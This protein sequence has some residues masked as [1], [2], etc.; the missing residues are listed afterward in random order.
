M[1]RSSYLLRL[2]RLFLI[3]WIVM[4]VATRERRVIR[5]SK[6]T[7]IGH[8]CRDYFVWPALRP[9]PADDDTTHVNTHFSHIHEH[10]T[11]FLNVPLEA[12]ATTKPKGTKKNE[13]PPSRLRSRSDASL[14]LQL[15]LTRTPLVLQVPIQN[16]SHRRS[17]QP[18]SP[19]GQEDALRVAR[20]IAPRQP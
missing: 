17:P 16:P 11:V 10:Q 8:T 18:H 9:L 1:K 5:I 3:A 15:L 12:K 13:P 7:A 2:L 19:A 4:M 14:R 6:Q 20:E